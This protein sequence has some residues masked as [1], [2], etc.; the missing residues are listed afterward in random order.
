VVPPAPI[1][2]DEFAAWMQPLGPFGQQPRLAAGVSGGPHSLALAFLAHRWVAARGGSLLALIV[3]HGLRPG[4]ADEAVRVRDRL[5]GVGIAARVLALHLAPGPALQ[6]RARTARLGALLEACAGEARPWLLLG[7]HAHDQAET[8]LARALAGS[9][10]R[11][12][13]AMAPAHAQPE[14]LILRPLLGADP[15]RLE[16]TIAAASL[17]PER[18]P[19]NADARFL[20]V[21]L[22]G[23][24]DASA[25]PS[26]AE[27]ARRFGARRAARDGLLA[28]RLATCAVISRN[29][30]A[31]IDLAAL[32]DDAIA[33]EALGTLV[34]LIGGAPYD[35]DAA[36][37]AALLACGHGTLGGA[38]LH[39]AS[40][41]S[42]LLTREPSGLAAPVSAVRGAF[43]DGR[44][45]LTGEGAA[46]H[47]LGPLGDTA[48]PFRPA[49]PLPLPAT[50]PAIRD[51]HGRLAALPT[52]D[53]PSSLA[54][55]SFALAFSPVG[56][57]A[58]GWAVPAV[59]GPA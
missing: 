57:V 26:L 19:S 28:S 22:R 39:R 21:R 40:G 41:R 23:V 42:A 16:A 12:L 33:V 59:S 49:R 54:C 45:R 56:G 31:R 6:A 35:P 52:L 27:A 9:G 15:A 17:T 53:Y 1:G 5:T 43:W 55:R 58:A 36:A 25:Q 20:R 30:H 8:L 51:P 37:V 50:L 3:D 2:E 4:S 47:W 13:A 29:G 44:F 11:G 46:D 48:L 32:G 38:W 34:R 7:H 14:A 24:I 10:A 18:D